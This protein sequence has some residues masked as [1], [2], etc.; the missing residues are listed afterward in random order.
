MITGTT[1]CLSVCLSRRDMAKDDRVTSVVCET[2]PH[3]N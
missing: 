2:V 1:T 3:E